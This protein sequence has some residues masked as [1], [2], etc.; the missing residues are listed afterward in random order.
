M[1]DRDRPRWVVI[2]AAGSGARFGGDTPKQYLPLAGRTVIQW[3]M[4]PFLARDDVAGIVVVVAPEDR[5]WGTIRPAS[6]KLVTAIGGSQRARSVL[7]GLEALSDRADSEDWVLVHD[8]ARPCLA[9]DDLGKLIDVIV[10]EETGGLLA[11]PVPDTLKLADA[12]DRVEATLDRSAVWRALTPQ[13]F[14]HGPLI[15]ALRSSLTAGAEVT[16]E[17][18]AMERAGLRPRLVAGRPDNIKITRP[19]DLVLA[20]SILGRTGVFRCG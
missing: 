6:E 19:E 13:M 5:V 1:T 10:G 2:P 15:D 8:A 7:N 20:E 18:S 12:G 4:E 17:S 11:V 9:G 16:D 3:A 14:R